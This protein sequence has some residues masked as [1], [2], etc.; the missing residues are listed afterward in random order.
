MVTETRQYIFDPFFTSK[1]VGR[2]TGLGL[3]I[4]KHIVETHGGM[5]GAQSDL[6]QGSV[7]WCRFPA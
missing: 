2:G 3:A 5:V 1:A 4:V 7:F 6:G